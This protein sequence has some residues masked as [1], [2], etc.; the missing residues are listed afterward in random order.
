MPEVQVNGHRLFYEDQG[1][2][3]PVVL[4][5]GLGGDHRAFAVTTRHLAPK[6]RVLALD[7]RD[8]GRSDRSCSPYVT[9]DMADDVAAWLDALD[10]PSARVV[11]HSLGGLVA[12]ELAVRHPHKVSALVLASTHAGPNPWRS[13]IIESWIVARHAL[14]PADF[15]RVSMPLLV[16]PPFF[17]NRAQVDGLIRFAERNEWPQSPDAF[18]RQARAALTHRADTPVES[19]SV[20]T[21]VLH[22]DQD[23][24]NP[25][26][27]ARDLA[28]RIKQ[29]E[30]V[31][32][33]GVG[34]LPHIEAGPEFRRHL[35]RFF[36]SLD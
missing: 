5:S 19:I 35:S 17:L 6:Y 28:S 34:H 4:L 25:P 11:G 1:S 29:A 9:S 20:P 2:G 32:L 13:G 21:L 31:T 22:G 14:P 26:D 18:E 36:E 24:V 15:A 33:P 3:D 27:V 10:V 30:L 8:A 7:N 16:A 23:L 12:Q